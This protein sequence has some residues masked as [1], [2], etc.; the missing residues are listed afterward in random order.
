MYFKVMNCI[1]VGQVVH[2]NDSAEV[3]FKRAIEADQKA[4]VDNIYIYLSVY[5][6]I[7]LS[8]CIFLSICIYIYIYI[9]IYICVHI[10]LYMYACLYLYVSCI[11]MRRWCTIMTRRRCTTSAPSKLTRRLASLY[12]SISMYLCR[13]I[14]I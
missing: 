10:Y 1:S 8:I 9:Y 2:D 14:S 7:Y 11:D 3:Y 6:S 12:L 4:R 5:L 13:Y